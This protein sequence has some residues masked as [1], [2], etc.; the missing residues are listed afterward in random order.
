RIEA[1]AT[2]AENVIIGSHCR[3]GMGASV[4]HAIIEDH[5][6]IYPGARIGQDGFG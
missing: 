1:N 4:S 6:R 2:I 3:V 5:V